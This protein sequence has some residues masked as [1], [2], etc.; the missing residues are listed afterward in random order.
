M[1]TTLVWLRRDLRIRDNPALQAAASAGRVVPVFVWSPEEEGEWA[2]GAASRWWL[3]HSLKSLERELA[4]RG[5]P[6]VL[7]RGPAAQALARLAAEAGAGAVHY[8]RRFEPASRRQEEAVEARLRSLGVE[9]RA[10][11]GDSLFEP[12]SVRTL[13]GRP[14]KVFTPY[15]NRCGE[16]PAPE[17]PCGE[18]SPL[19]GAAP[20][21]ASEALESWE[22]LPKRDWGEGL[23]RAP[24]PGEPAARAQLSAFLKR[25][26]GYRESRDVP[27]A[28]GSSLLSPR[29]HFGELDVRR[30]WHEALPL[31]DAPSRKGGF[32][33]ELGWRDFGRHVLVHEP[34]TPR[35]PH[36]PRFAGFR[37]RRDERALRAWQS[38]RTGYPM[39]DA[40]MR[41]LWVTGLMHNRARM[42]VASFLVKDLLLDWREGARWFWDTL[43]DADLANNTLGWQWS[44]GCGTDAAPFFRIFNPVEQGRRFDAEG[45]YV[46]RWLPALARLDAR[47]VHAPWTAPAE[48]LERAGLVLGRDYPR[49]IVD[50]GEARARALAAYGA[51]A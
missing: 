9:T 39:V 22:L 36:D 49:P 34:Q 12:E 18:P 23:S 21:P 32:L 26:R 8:A 13:Q 4:E 38:G 48:L 45:A 19:R 30:V 7:R 43:V 50:H 51:S 46:K 3:H 42:I 10:F 14:Y 40:A 47:W 33:G 6:L 44:A 25:A 29:L 16:L 24:T 27:A 37:W 2:P 1:R 15:W 20:A 5:A 41:Q 28:E 35:A 31:G 17:N 11:A